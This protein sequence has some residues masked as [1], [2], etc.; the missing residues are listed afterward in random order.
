MYKIDINQCIKA[1]SNLKMDLLGNFYFSLKGNKEKLRDFYCK[2]VFGLP[3]F[4]F[5]FFLLKKQI[6]SALST[7]KKDLIW[8]ALTSTRC[9]YFEQKKHKIVIFIAIKRLE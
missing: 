6:V 9:P 8:V 5:F 1:K 7:H 4:I 3:I 2:V